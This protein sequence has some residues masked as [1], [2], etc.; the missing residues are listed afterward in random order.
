MSSKEELQQR[1]IL[2]AR[3]YG[4]NTVLYRHAVG[5]KVG[6]NV[7][8]MECLA[9]LFFKGM[10]SPTEL[11]TYTGLSS[12]ATTAMLDRLEKSGLIIRQANPKDRRSTLVVVAEDA[13][14]KVG[15]FFVKI[16]Q[17]QDKLMT[18]YSDEELTC[19][20]D[21]LSKT[22]TIWEEE[23]KKLHT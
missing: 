12:G 7:T 2:A 15:P 23:R 17:A 21:F 14:T 20:A 3:D 8:D 4:I 9:V 1:V 18:G 22:S 6:L 13:R 16:R 10:S 19:I 11:A 5:A